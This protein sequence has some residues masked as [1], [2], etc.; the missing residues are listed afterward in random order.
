MV[1]ASEAVPVLQARADNVSNPQ[2]QCWLI[3]AIA[4]LGNRSN[5]PFV[6]K[7]LYSE[8][9]IVGMCAAESLQQLTGEDLHL[10]IHPGPISP[11]AVISKGKVWWENNASNWK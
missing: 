9:Q 8:N 2:T 6:A 11:S 5:V 7:R 4:V 3:G 1:K 10:D